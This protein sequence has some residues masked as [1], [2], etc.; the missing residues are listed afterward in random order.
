MSDVV[1]GFIAGLQLPP[2]LTVTEW[3][4]ANVILPP[5]VA[6]PGPYRVTRTPYARG[7]M[8]AVHEADAR[9]IVYMT[10]AQISKTQCMLNI[11]GY[12][13]EHDPCAMIFVVPTSIADGFSKAKIGPFIEAS[14]ILAERT[15]W[16]GTRA[17]KGTLYRKE[18]P[19]GFLNI[20]GASDP[21]ALRMQS[22]RI[23]L[24]DEIDGWPVRAG[25]EGDPIGLA[26]NRTETYANA[27]M[28][29]SSTPTHKGH[30]KVEWYFDRSDQRYFYIPMPCCGEMHKLVWR[31]VKWR[32]GEPWTA[33]YLC[34]GCGTFNSD[35]MLKI[36]IRSPEARWIAERPEVRDI[37]GFRIWR[38]YSPW[39]SMEK[40]VADYEKSRHDDD[41]LERFTNTVLGET[42]DPAENIRTTP[43]AVFN[44]RVTIKPGMIP[45]GACVVTAGVDVQRDRLEVLFCAF[46]PGK[47]V[48]LLQH[49]NI[50]GDPSA[51][52][53]W[54][55]LEELLLRRWAHE[56][57][58]TLTR[59]VEGVAIDS[60]YLTQRVYDFAAKAHRIGRPWYAIKG[61]PGPGQIAW[62]VAKTRHALLGGAKLHHVGVDGLKTEIAAR[63]SSTDP[64]ENFIYVANRD[65]FT[66]ERIEQLFAEK[67]ALVINK[68]GFSTREWRLIP[69]RRN[70]LWDMT[71]YAEAVHRSLGINHAARL[72]AMR[73]PTTDAIADITR[74]MMQQ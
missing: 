44:S 66:L 4:E 24:G 52:M 27:R 43:E 35:A 51:D 29:V 68:R 40:I 37:V 2:D 72:A 56:G 45:K 67:V 28:I 1:K 46:G 14:P 60:G 30:S 21:A 15:G 17:G 49:M 18:F 63:L 34:E 50:E 6:E 26:A 36:A 16:N 61:Q 64:N 19:G 69:G 70:E 42:Y 39:S 57:M 33:E 47:K 54:S 12:H 11:V 9:V 7:M 65:E 41:K 3:A 22:V 25:K 71:I 10:S 13:I 48:W 8:N 20:A 53:V 23:F 5:E 58:P 74:L 38:I 59:P 62:D 31:Q 73:A 55:R 32:E